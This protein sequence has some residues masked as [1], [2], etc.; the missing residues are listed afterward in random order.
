[1]ARKRHYVNNADFLQ[2]MIDFKKLREDAEESGNTE[3]RI[4]KY[5]G[6]C[7]F[8]IATRLS[9]KGNFSGYSFKEEMISDGLENAVK[10]AKNFNPEKSKNPFAYF[11]QV[12]YFAFL[13]RIEL[14]KKHQYT[15]HKVTGQASISGMLAD[16]AVDGSLNHTQTDAVANFVQSFEDKLQK[17]KQTA[18]EAALAKFEEE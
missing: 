16:N 4:P 12:I 3:P 2:A 1:M 11:T 8:Q 9:R 17:K 6:E 18:K 14:E 5:I 13:R 10:C 7:F 15:M